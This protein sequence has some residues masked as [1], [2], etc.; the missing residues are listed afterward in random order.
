[1]AKHQKD[2]RKYE[3]PVIVTL[4]ELAMSMGGGCSTGSSAGATCVGGGTAAASCHNGGSADASCHEG[5]T[6]D[7]SCVNGT[8]PTVPS[9]TTGDSA[10]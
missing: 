6:A 1:M 8:I 9:C 7:A 3:A 10:E 4:G 2:K 5:G